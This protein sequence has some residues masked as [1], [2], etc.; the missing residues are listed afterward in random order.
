MLQLILSRT[1]LSKT[2]NAQEKWNENTT[3]ENEAIW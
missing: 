3:Q 2:K 1:N